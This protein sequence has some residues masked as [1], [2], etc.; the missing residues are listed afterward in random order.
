MK[1]TASLQS[2]K[3]NG[4][5][6]PVCNHFIPTSVL[7]LDSQSDVICQTCVL[8]L[9]IEKENSRKAMEILKKVVEGQKEID[10]L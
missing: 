7:E 9:S 10:R 3:Q 6:C 2:T 8:N 5:G 4:F 1:E